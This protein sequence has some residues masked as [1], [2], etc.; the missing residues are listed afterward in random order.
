MNKS[1][2]PVSFASPPSNPKELTLELL[3]YCYYIHTPIDR[4][5]CFAVLVDDDSG[6]VPHQIFFS[7]ARE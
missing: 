3:V 1:S 2:S 4:R 7:L 5:S 6:D